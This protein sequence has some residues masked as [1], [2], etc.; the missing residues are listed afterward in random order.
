MKSAPMKPDPK[1]P[2]QFGFTFLEVMIVLAIVIIVAGMAIPNLMSVIQNM[3]TSGDARDLNS[4]ILL[5]KMR[6]S[7][8]YARA[9]VY[10]DLSA[11]TFYIQ[12]YQAGASQWTT[13]GGTQNLSKNVLYGFD[14]VTA[15]PSGMSSLAQA[16]ACLKDDLVSTNTYANSAC[17]MFNSRGI[18]VDSSWVPTGAYAIYINDGRSAS[19]VTVT[20][21]GLTQIWRADDSSSAAWVQ[22]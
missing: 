12:T 3:R 6:A 10:F 2:R 16:P 14:A 17:I 20:V 13:D 22:R 8:D 7:S 19:G 9:R 18:P 15:V 11:N 4:T 5:A 21:T 1:R